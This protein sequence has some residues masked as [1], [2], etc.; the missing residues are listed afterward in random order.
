MRIA[1]VNHAQTQQTSLL[2]EPA[3]A[4]KFAYTEVSRESGET[5]W[6]WPLEEPLSQRV[7]ATGTLLDVS[8]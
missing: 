5:L 8:A 4:H 1:T 3:G 2:I 6:R 7:Q